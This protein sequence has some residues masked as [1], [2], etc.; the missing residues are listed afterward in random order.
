MLRQ[1]GS[2]IALELEPEH[3]EAYQVPVGKVAILRIDL[4][5]RQHKWLPH[6]VAPGVRGGREGDR[7]TS[8]SAGAHAVSGWNASHGLS[9]STEGCA[10]I[11]TPTSENTSEKPRAWLQMCATIGLPGSL[12]KQIAH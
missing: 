7:V 3:R 11:T 10:T 9:A 1:V 6:P 4:H 5:G 12:G 2:E 8:S